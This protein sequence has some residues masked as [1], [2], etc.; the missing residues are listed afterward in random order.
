MM[1][2]VR[3]EGGRGRRSSWCMGVPPNIRAIKT[4]TQ[5]FSYFTKIK[6][7]PKAQVNLNDVRCRDRDL[8]S[9]L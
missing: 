8:T 6:Y 7:R 5:H 4:K 2:E 3:E 1:V 9:V